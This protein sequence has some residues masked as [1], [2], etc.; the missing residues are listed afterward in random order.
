M[1]TANH[2]EAHGK[3]QHAHHFD[4]AEHEYAT[5]KQGVWAFLVTEVLMFG[6][7]FV[8]YIIFHHIYPEQKLSFK[9][10]TVTGIEGF[11]DE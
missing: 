6:G 5:T 8:A 10:T 4:S 9:Y 1:S 2:P 3:H 7:L 11:K